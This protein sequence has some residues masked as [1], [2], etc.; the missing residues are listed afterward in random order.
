MYKAKLSLW[1]YLLYEIL[2]SLHRLHYL[3]RRNLCAQ[4]SENSKFSLDVILVGLF[5]PKIQ[6]LLLA[7]SPEWF[8][9]MKVHSQRI[10]IT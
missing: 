4:L 10:F 6:D 1:P 9:F 5:P 7:P 2:F 8:F 3:G